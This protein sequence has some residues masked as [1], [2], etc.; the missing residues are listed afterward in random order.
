MNNLI[1]IT[2]QLIIW[3]YFDIIFGSYLLPGKFYL[4]SYVVK[5]SIPFSTYI[6]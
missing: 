3:Y 2:I 1:F 4:G 5:P 6:D